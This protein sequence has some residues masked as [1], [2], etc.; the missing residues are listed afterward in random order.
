MAVGIDDTLGSKAPGDMVHN[1][2]LRKTGREQW[3]F[4]SSFEFGTSPD[5]RLHE[6][7]VAGEHRQPAFIVD[8]P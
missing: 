5:G 3:A 1:L 7:S 2:A 6:V 8:P 4:G